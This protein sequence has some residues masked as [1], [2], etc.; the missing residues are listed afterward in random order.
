VE[1]T[2]KRVGH[3]VGWAGDVVKARDVLVL[4]L[5]N[6]EQAE[7]VRRSRCCRC[8]SSPLPERGA[9]VVT[10]GKHSAFPNVKSGRERIEVEEPARELEVGIRDGTEGVGLSD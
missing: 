8:A 10:L 4:S 5:M 7:E 1:I 6:P 2:G 3:V 9:E